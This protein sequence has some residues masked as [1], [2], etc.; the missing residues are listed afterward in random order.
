[1]RRVY[2]GAIG[3]LAS[4]AFVSPAMAGERVEPLNQYIVEGTPAELG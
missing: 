1:M 2:L 4:L 3:V